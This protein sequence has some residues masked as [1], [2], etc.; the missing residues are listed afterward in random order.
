M[1]NYFLEHDFTHTL[2]GMVRNFNKNKKITLG[3][4]SKANNAGG[5]A[6]DFV[7]Q[8]Q[9]DTKSNYGFIT[10]AT[11]SFPRNGSKTVTFDYLPKVAPHRLRFEKSTDGVRVTGTGLIYN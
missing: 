3:L 4:N 11:A 9:I 6:D 10:V 1:P 5:R 2:N 7:V 8:L